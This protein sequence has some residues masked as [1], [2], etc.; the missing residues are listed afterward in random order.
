M[1]LKTSMDFTA[2]SRAAEILKTT[3][4][5]VCKGEGDISILLKAKKPQA[6][7]FSTSS[8]STSYLVPSTVRALGDAMWF[9][10]DAVWV[11]PLFSRSKCFKGLWI[12]VLALDCTLNT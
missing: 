4:T 9:W 2:L 1:F 11:F 10:R 5:P 12:I 3:P 6:S 7:Y 8:H